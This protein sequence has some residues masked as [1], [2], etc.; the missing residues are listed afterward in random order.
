MRFPDRRLAALVAA[1]FAAAY[2]VFGLFR[3]W[4]FGSNGYDLGIFDQAVWHLSRF[5]APA[6]TI[7][8][9]SNILG[10]H[11]YPV[12]GLFVPFYWILPGPE[13]LIVVQA[14]LLAASTIPVYLFA[15]ARLAQGPALALTAAYALY[16]GMQRTME[17]DVH[18]MAF[19][20]LAIATAILALD[21]RQWR[22]FWVAAVSLIFIKE[23]LIPALTG[24]GILL[25]LQ[26]DYRRG[27][28][29]IVGSVAAFLLVVSVVVPSLNDA[30]VYNHASSYR[31]LLAQPW[32]IPIALVTPAQKVETALMWFVP[33]A[34][35]SFRSPLVVLALPLVL[36]RLLSSSPTHWATIFHYTAPLAP[37]I[38][39]SAADGLARLRPS[40]ARL[41]LF[42]TLIVLLCAILPGRLPLW[43]LF[44][45]AHYT[46]TSSDR[47]G[48]ALLSMVPPE[49]SVV[50]QAAIAPHLS[51]REQIHVLGDG[52]PDA[53]FIIASAWLSPWP[54][55]SYDELRILLEAY[56]RRGYTVFRERNGWL[57][58]RASADAAIE[59]R[60]PGR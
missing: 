8:G 48:Y 29:L 5:E 34:L 17:F 41:R 32:R 20:P 7:S 54:A 44:R 13:T 19:A 42:V 37:I 33:F 15:R 51:R 43:R 12:I 47:D 38:A 56:Q 36:A 25:V 14:V 18:E 24:I 11:F 28:A 60:S 57:L 9:F 26:R 27:M 39:M 31:A 46:L 3:H 23:D 6:S 50:A 2:A 16:W 58:L 35:L 30:G 22:L 40:P 52:A 21:R 55:A 10:D 4:R 49:A 59:Q 53:E 45:P 1:A